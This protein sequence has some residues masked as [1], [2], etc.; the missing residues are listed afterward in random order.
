MK[1]ALVPQGL[2]ARFAHA[3]QVELLGAVEE[4]PQGPRLRLRRELAPPPESAPLHGLHSWRS[5]AWFR[6]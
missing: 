1:R 6:V 2:P 3:A 5:R 4:T